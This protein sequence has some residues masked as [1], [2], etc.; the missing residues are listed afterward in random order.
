MRAYVFLQG[1]KSDCSKLT[2]ELNDYAS[3]IQ[4]ET[5]MSLLIRGLNLLATT[6]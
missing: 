5:K 1:Q 6:V 2:N 4:L 3:L